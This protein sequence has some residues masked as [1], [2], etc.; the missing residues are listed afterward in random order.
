MLILLIGSSGYART[1]SRPLQTPATYCDQTGYAIYDGGNQVLDTRTGRIQA[2]G[3]M[4]EGPYPGKPDDAARAFLF[5]HQQ[6]LGMEP[7]AKNL[8]V[9]R[10]AESVMGY[11]VTFV[12]I[13]DNVP[14]Y[15]GTV[16]VTI[17]TGGYVKFYFSGLTLWTESV[18]VMTQVSSEVAEEIA[19]HYLGASGKPTSKARME[20]V[21]WAGDNS[22]FS[23]CWKYRTSYEEPFGDWEILVDARDGRIR[24]CLNRMQTVNGSGLVFRPDPCSSSGNAYGTAGYVDNNDVETPQVTAQKVSVTLLDISVSGAPAVYFLAGPWCTIANMEAPN[25]TPVTSPTPTFNFTR[26]DQGFEDVMC[27]YYIDAAQR[28][29]QSLGF[30]NIQHQSF[31][32]DPHGVSGQQYAYYNSN[33]NYIACG[34]GYVDGNNNPTACVDIA[35]DGELLWH[36]YGHAIHADQIPG[37]GGAGDEDAIGEGFSDYWGASYGRSLT[38]FF[39]TEILNWGAHACVGTAGILPNFHYPEDAG[40]PDPHVSGRIWTQALYES[41]VASNRTAINR[42]VIQSHFLYGSPMTMPA[43]ALALLTADLAL[44]QGGYAHAISDACVPRGILSRPGNDVCPGYGITSLPFS[45]VTSTATADNN[46]ANCAGTTSPDIV[47]TLRLACPYFV[48]VSLCGAHPDGSYDTGLE[49][50]TGGSC[51]GSTMMLCSDDACGAGNRQSTLQFVAAASTDYYIIVHGYSTYA[52]PVVVNVTGSPF[53][54]APPN[55]VCPGTAITSLPYIDYGSTCSANNNYNGCIG[56]TSAD[57]VYSMELTS[58]QTVTVSLCDANYDTGLEVRTGVSCPGDIPVACN[59]DFCALSSQV[60]FSATAYQPYYILV[61]GYSA[62]SRGNFTLNASGVPFVAGNDSCPGA[63]I[64]TLP[65]SDAGNTYCSTNDWP[66]CGV[67]STRDVVYRYTSQSCQTL[68]ASLCGSVF[69]TEIEVR[70][71]GSCPGAVS[72]GCNDDFCGL[73]SFLQFPATEGEV[74]YFLVHGYGADAGGYLFQLSA[75]PGGMQTNDVC[76]GATPILSLPYQDYGS[77]NCATNSRANCVGM[78]SPEVFYRLNVETC[79]DV[80]ARLCYSY[81]DTGLEVRTGGACPGSTFVTCNDDNLGCN[82]EGSLQS[83]AQFRAIAGM[84]YFLIIHGFSSLS[85][86]Y[87]LDVVGS[88][89][90]PE[91]LVVQRQ[92]NNAYL[93]WTPVSSTGTVSY[94]VY[95]ATVPDVATIPANQ[96]AVTTNPFYAD[97]NIIPNEQLKFF[98]AVTADGP[99]LALQTAESPAINPALQSAK[100]VDPKMTEATRGRMIPAY[101]DPAQIEGPNLTKLPALEA[102]H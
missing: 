102:N 41:E 2:V 61:H 73:Q 7:S 94:R 1:D 27:Y 19:L 56:G 28:Y 51:P 66:K 3:L 92:G 45:N 83:I 70:R 67:N 93:D 65:Y 95:R 77:T 24:R 57:V 37:W 60:Q 74:Y 71:G 53:V 62:G 48:T 82:P 36:E 96:I 84:D 68:S 86:V 54:V 26:T 23:P 18:D 63:L 12:R 11:H 47:Y 64:V 8:R 99:T 98:Y 38:P 81:Y 97:L 13:V 30:N 21:V 79:T 6:W 14:V 22:D 55:D 35:E 17:D 15:P 44:Y 43:A 76:A 4:S 90:T 87:I 33:G 16:V 75:T 100:F 91:S 58:C 88:T 10:V 78:N 34:E 89:C 29:L 20:L 69:D 72:V 46:Y 50:R 49:I 9:E 39:N 59:D 52:G 5:A 32:V 40:H 25:G 42:S 101:I 31:P 80:M 85:G